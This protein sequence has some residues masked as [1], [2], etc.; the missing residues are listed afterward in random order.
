MFRNALVYT[1]ITPANQN[2]PREPRKTPR[3]FLIKS[4]SC[5]RQ[6]HDCRP[7]RKF[8]LGSRIANGHAQQMLHRLKQRLRLQHHALTA[9]KRTVV[10]G[11]MPVL[12]E[13][14]QILHVHFNN[15]GLSRA[16]QNPVIQRPRKKIRKNGDEIKTH[17][18]IQRERC[19]N[20][21]RNHPHARKNGHPDR[22]GPTLFLLLRSCE[23]VGP[24]SGGISLPLSFV[25]NNA[26]AATRNSNRAN[27]PAA[28]LQYAVP[29]HR[30][31]CKYLQ[32]AESTVRPG[33]SPL[34]AA[35]FHARSRPRRETAHPAPYPIIAGPS[36]SSTA[37]KPPPAFHRRL[38]TPRTQ[39]NPPQKIA[40]QAS[41]LAAQTAATHPGR[42]ISPRH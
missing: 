20:N 13:H 17:L 10:H 31:A 18:V 11:A 26:T 27:P 33:L 5:S 22:S 16:P 36:P 28:S 25:A 12:G 3:R 39:S 41:S 9:T 29:R 1:F 35:A 19:L 30:C 8:T 24:R 4:L 15:S 42:E 34:P 21:R 2:N 32:P 37:K 7:A 6:Q 14:P 38:Q 40:P 23:G